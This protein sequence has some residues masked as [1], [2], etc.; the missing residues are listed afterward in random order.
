MNSLPPKSRDAE[1]R[2]VFRR[3]ENF[4]RGQPLLPR[5][6]IGLIILTCTLLPVGCRRD[7]SNGT[8][9]PSPSP[10]PT[11][12]PSPTPS[13]AAASADA[14]PATFAAAAARSAKEASD[15]EAEA[16]RGNAD[17][18]YAA[19]Q[20][21]LNEVVRLEGQIASLS[22]AIDT[23]LSGA[24]LALSTAYHAFLQAESAVFY[25]DPEAEAG[26]ALPFGGLDG[27]SSWPETP[28]FAALDQSLAAYPS[29]PIAPF[30]SP[31]TRSDALE[32]LKAETQSLRT[33]LQDFAT[34]WDPD[35]QDNFRNQIF[36]TDSS[37]A[38]RKIFQGLLAV[39]DQ[40]IFERSSSSSN[41]D[42][43]IGRLE[44]I[45]GI[46][47]GQYATLQ[48][49]TVWTPGLKVLVQRSKP[50]AATDLSDT[51]DR[52]LESWRNSAPLPDEDRSPSLEDLRKQLIAAAERLG[53][54]VESLPQARQ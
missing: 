26:W 20:D 23:D 45:K 1:T 38:T 21:A 7:S 54:P 6:A 47:E 19:A 37:A 40:L 48:Y 17:L 16:V 32:N 14:S 22:P 24:N 25:P 35:F 41:R 12:S 51:I 8:P 33:S 46:Y 30:G 34:D 42:R 49:T 27:N 39:T 36:L 10:S 5:I 11:A 29:L 28:G 13:S 44:G 31:G 53:Y 43:L 3:N 50:S 18:I 52:L 15:P 9:T 4:F 2:S